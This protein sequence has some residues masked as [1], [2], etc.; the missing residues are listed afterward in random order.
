MRKSRKRASRKRTSRKRAS[1]RRSRRVSRKKTLK[2]SAGGGSSGPPS[3]VTAAAAADAWGGGVYVGDLK[4][5]VMHGQGTMI[6]PNGDK[7]V[8]GWKDNKFHGFGTFIYYTFNN[9]YVGDWKNGMKNG[10]GIFTHDPRGPGTRTT[11]RNIPSW[12]EEAPGEWKYVG[13]WKDDFFNGHGTMTW[14]NGRQY[15]GEWKNGHK[16]GKGT[17]TWEDGQYIGEWKKPVDSFHSLPRR[18]RFVARSSDGRREDGILIFDSPNG[19]MWHRQ[20]TVGMKHTPM[21]ND[22]PLDELM[23]ILPTTGMKTENIEYILDVISGHDYVPGAVCAV[24]AHS[25]IRTHAQHTQPHTHT[26]RWVPASSVSTSRR[27]RMLQE[28]LRE[29][30]RQHNNYLESL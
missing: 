25:R 26:R 17:M 11:N 20:R 9:K 7:Y 8:G 12:W 28:D 3:G 4:N 22:Y 30:E 1:R 29:R 24:C 23:H 19:T 13:E 14:G 27:R 5:G 2:Y 15:I 18:P 6:W 10:Y 21:G 16:D